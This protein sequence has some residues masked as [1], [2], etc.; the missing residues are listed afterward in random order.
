MKL[1]LKGILTPDTCELAGIKGYNMSGIG[2]RTVMTKKEV[3]SILTKASLDEVEAIAKSIKDKS[4]IKLIKPPQKTLIMVKV[5]EPVKQS[6]F[7]LGEVLATECMVMVEGVRG[8]SVIAGDDFEKAVSI[9]VIDG[10]LNKKEGVEII[11]KQVK[12]LGQSQEK[13]REKLNGA[14]MK[15]KVNFSVMGE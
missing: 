3:S 2:E 9:A 7:Y 13:E 10:F 6:L 12:K 11:E 15:S 1:G 14:I 4:D 5:R 8:A